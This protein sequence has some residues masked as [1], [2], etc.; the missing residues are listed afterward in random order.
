M[1]M[2]RMCDQLTFFLYSESLFNASQSFLEKAKSSGTVEKL[3][4]VDHRESLLPSS[5]SESPAKRSRSRSSSVSSLDDNSVGDGEPDEDK[6][7]SGGQKRKKKTRTVFS[8][9][10]VFQLE[11]TFDVKR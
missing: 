10:Q 1:T 3:G 11:S 7:G 6:S 2:T 4:V 8:R 5:P 9:S